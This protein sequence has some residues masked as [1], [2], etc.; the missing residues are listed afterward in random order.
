MEEQ[1]PRTGSPSTPEAKHWR[2]ASTRLASMSI[3]MMVHSAVDCAFM[4]GATHTGTAASLFDRR[5]GDAVRP[6]SPRCTSGR[7]YTSCAHAQLR[8]M[9]RSGRSVVPRL[10][11]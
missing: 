10:K 1:A 3:I 4:P 6:H 8:A 7:A 9:P 2:A 5:P 11:P